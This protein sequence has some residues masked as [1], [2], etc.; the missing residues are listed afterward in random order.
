MCVCE[1]HGKVFVNG[2]IIKDD[3]DNTDEACGVGIT[4]LGI[5]LATYTLPRPL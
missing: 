5:T 1:V 4:V 3:V 2:I